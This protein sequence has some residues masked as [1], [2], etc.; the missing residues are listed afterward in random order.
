MRYCGAARGSAMRAKDIFLGPAGLRSG[1]RLLIFLAITIALQ[2]GLQE[3]V[4][5]VLR[6]RGLVAPEG[7]YSLVFLASDTITLI[8]VV[9][10][11]WVMAKWERRRLTDY[12]LPGKNAFGWK[13]WEG[14]ALGYAGVS[15][16]ILLIFLA[17]G[18]S[19]G[20]L[21]LHG[22][23]LVRAALL[24]LLASLA[25]GFAEEYLFRG[26]S[27]FILTQG[28]GFWPAAFLIS[29]LFGALHYFTKPYERWPDWASTGLIALLLC[30]TLRR[31]GDLRFAIGFHA[32]FDFGAIF[33][34]S[35]PNGG[36]L[37]PDRLLTATF[38]GSDWLTGGRLG[39]EASLLVFP[40]IGAMFLVFHL[41][42]RSPAEA[43]K[44][45]PISRSI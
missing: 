1:W 34:Y 11:N 41:L 30:L 20:S 12:G 29:F 22:A 36:Q 13:F 25:I 9:V 27:Q 33:V 5:L 18:Y 40:V 14:A 6:A 43:S 4:L 15:L 17:G 7:L 19:P 24:W 23:A 35:G 32:A 26:Y 3:I 39:P 8:A 37:A 45:A 2:A 10:A 44:T 31:T 42:Y 16:L 38:H 28:I 21:A